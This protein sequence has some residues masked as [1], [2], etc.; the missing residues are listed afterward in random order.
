[1][2]VTNTSPDLAGRAEELRRQLAY[3]SYRYHV[4]DAPIISDAAYDSLYRELRDLETEHPEL[5]T[6]DSPTQRVGGAPVEGFRKVQHPAPMLS[7][8]NAFSVEEVRAWGERMRRLV[9]DVPMDFVVEPKMDGLTV[10][11]H[12]TDGVFTLGA[13]RG[14][15]IEGEDVT[16][17][18]RTL[19]SVPL[20]IPVDVNSDVAA[21]P[22]L[23]VR[24]EVLMHKDAFARLNESRVADGLEPYA[25]PRNTSAG[26]LRQLDPRIT[27]TRPLTLY[28]YAV[29]VGPRLHSQWEALEY[30]QMMGFPVNSDSKHA[31]TLDEAIAIAEEWLARKSSLNYDADGIVLKVNSFALQEE[32]G[33][34][35]SAPRSAI[36]FKP[37]PQE[38]VTVL[39]R[40]A[41]NVG[42]T[43]VVTPQALM[44]PV[45]IGG[46]TVSQATLHNADYIA[47]RDI[48][49]GDT[50]VIKRAGDVIPQ[51]LRAVVELRLPDAEPWHMPPTCPS[52]GEP[53]VRLPG[54]AAT[55]CVN[56]AC[57]AQLRRHV[58]HFAGRGAMDIVGLGEK[59]VAQV[60]D[61]GLVHDVADLYHLKEKRDALL[62]LEGFGEKKVD[63]LLA[64]IEASKD[65]PLARLLFA[66]GIQHVGGTIAETLARRF[67]A[68]E[69]LM[70]ASLDDV[71]SISGLGPQIAESVVDYFANP[72][73]REVIERLKTAGV[74]TADAQAAAPSDGRFAGQTFVLTGRLPNMTR[75]EAKSRIE[76]RGGRVTD[77]VTRKT[78]YVV[79]GE[80]PGSKLDK[81]RQLGVAV[82]D[83]ADLMRLLEG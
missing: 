61:Q 8:D 30:L 50:V 4:L 53:L 52:C 45:R 60:V 21:P 3:H 42:R 5:V 59:I 13:T 51:V 78:T 9:G 70:A 65:R 66:L 41:V 63:N 43:G 79:V 67:G 69:P 29:V 28:T 62:T 39:R 17:N 54:E 33:V 35:G 34:V 49:E 40:I 56:A 32:L 20:R 83:E 82:L 71:Q 44:D 18:L 27:A 80:E 77:S 25:N 46:V 16:A 22:T 26:A 14:N 68:I 1:M 23:V 10:V 58:E 76:S 55:Y 64:S 48:R 12:Y 2:T 15:G 36:A 73:N 47:E 7:L 38:G 72:R 19:P 75:D 74:R 31:D 37:A 6:P 24:G 81:A 57:P 11:L